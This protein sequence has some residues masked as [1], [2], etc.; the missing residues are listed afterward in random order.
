MWK[1][2]VKKG[3]FCVV[4][5]TSVMSES[6]YAQVS[7]GADIMSRYVW[8]GADFGNSPSIQPE[9]T[10]SRGGFEI[11]S[12][13][14]VATTGNPDGYEVDWFASYTFGTGAGD[15]SLYLTDYTFPVPGV[16][17][18]FS[19]ESHFLEAGIGISDIGGLPLDLF[20]GMFLTNDDDNSIYLELAYNLEMVSFHIG[21]TPGE[22]AMYGTS[23][24]AVINTGISAGKSV[25]ISES[26]ELGLSTSIILNPDS[27][28]LFFLFGISL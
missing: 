15:V 13:A 19:S 26:F 17:D 6:V 3:L 21:M 5:I 22:S 24:A 25:K 8:R 2:Y 27:E 23:G 16:G 11:G 18:Y 14:A 20:A 9:I 4:L 7:V 10:Y 1:R 28:D 12:W